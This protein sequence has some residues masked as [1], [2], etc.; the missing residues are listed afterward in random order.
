MVYKYICD[1]TTCIKNGIE[2]SVKKPMTDASR[3]EYCKE[4][5][6]KLRRS[7]NTLSISTGD[8]F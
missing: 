7:Y 5:D 1:N 2:V 4:C 6:S 8:G 3:V